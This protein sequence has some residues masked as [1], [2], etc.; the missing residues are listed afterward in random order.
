M[1]GFTKRRVC[2]NVCAMNA[3]CNPRE[4]DTVPIFLV[5]AA[6]LKARGLYG[7]ENLCPSDNTREVIQYLAGLG[8]H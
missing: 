7:A 2:Q 6:H 1:K 8:V 4:S 5:M 3:K